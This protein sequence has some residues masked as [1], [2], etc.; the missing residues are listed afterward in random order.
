MFRVPWSYNLRSL[1]V[2]R[3]ATLLTVVGI[4]ATV[5][6]LA[7]VLALRQGFTAMFV[8]N[9]RE[10]VAVFLRPGATNDQFAS[11]GVL[12]ARPT[13]TSALRWLLREAASKL[14]LQ[15]LSVGRSLDG[16]RGPSGS[17]LLRIE[18]RGKMTRWVARRHTK[19][20]SG[21]P[22]DDAA[23]DASAAERF[24]I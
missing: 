20:G 15:Q 6:V 13:P 12:I 9:G 16:C 8:E 3:S 22:E 7:G 1:W 10:D 17:L 4:G 11:P 2:R 5:A 21:P 14:R 24:R 23:H 19:P 18:P